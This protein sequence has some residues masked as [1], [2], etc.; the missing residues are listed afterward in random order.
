MAHLAGFDPDV[1]DRMLDHVERRLL[2]IEPAREDPTPLLVGILK[3]D[4][5][6][7]AG[8]R[9]GLPW[10][11]RIA[12]AQAH[13]EIIRDL[14]RVPRLHLKLAHLAVALV[15][16]SDGGDALGHWRCMRF[17]RISLGCVAG[18]VSD[19]RTVPAIV[20]RGRNPKRAA[21]QREPAHQRNARTHPAQGHRRS[22]TQGS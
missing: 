22:G 19:V 3:I 8:P 2:F 17:D 15:E 10:C 16:Q 21:N 4:L 20:L 14:E 6:K 1:I 13:D 11:G 7:S 9:I 18:H 5:N 12:G